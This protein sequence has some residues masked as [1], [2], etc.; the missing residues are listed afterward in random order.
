MRIQW[1]EDLALGVEEI[2]AQHRALYAHVDQLL[3][4]MAAGR[5]ADLASILEFLGTYALVH[6][7]TEE[8]LMREGGYPDLERHTALHRTFASELGE[9]VE[10]YRARG[11]TASL[12][13]DLCN[14]LTDW[15]REHLRGADAELGRWSRARQG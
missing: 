1:M 14:W 4:A 11:A 7:R 5:S 9:R 13:V 15:L 3:E 8:R 2:D 12:A 10:V 6:F